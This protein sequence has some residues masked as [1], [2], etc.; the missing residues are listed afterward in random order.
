MVKLQLLLRKEWRNAEGINHVK[1]IASSVGLTPT[2]AGTASVSAVISLV[3]FEA[4]F[5]KPVEGVDPRPPG[6][7]DFGSPGGYVSEDLPV[8][9]P[10]KGYIESISVAPPHT[11]MGRSS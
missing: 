6:Q 5:G 9:D 7:R 8:P 3:D 4:T 11:R 2:T 10:L 1:R